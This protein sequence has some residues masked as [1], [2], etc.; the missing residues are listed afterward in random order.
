MRSHVRLVYCCGFLFSNF[1]SHS[2]PK[3]GYP[4][5]F[6]GSLIQVF[7]VQKHHCFWIVSEFA[8]QIWN[9]GK[10]IGGECMT[11][12]LRVGSQS[13]ASWKWCLYSGWRTQVNCLHWLV[14]CSGDGEWTIS[15]STEGLSGVW[16]SKAACSF[17]KEVRKVEVS[18]LEALRRAG[19]VLKPHAH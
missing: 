14:P 19:V 3:G 6:Q 7:S 15:G 2:I 16:M 8:L 5:F 13:L 10:E 17:S 9:L 12:L 4:V 1:W 11:A 18:C